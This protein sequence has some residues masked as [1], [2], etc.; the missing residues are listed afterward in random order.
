MMNEP[1]RCCRTNHFV[2]VIILLYKSFLGVAFQIITPS[3]MRMKTVSNAPGIDVGLK[4]TFNE[5]GH[6]QLER[7]FRRFPK[8]CDWC[9]QAPF[10]CKARYV[11]GNVLIGIFDGIRWREMS[12]RVEH[13]F[14]NRKT[15]TLWAKPG[16]GCYRHGSHRSRRAVHGVACSLSSLYNLRGHS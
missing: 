9:H 14:G 11:C 2:L 13:W 5:H 15:R 4:D 7:A 16:A 10:I 1:K 6:L 12:Q 8:V 3:N